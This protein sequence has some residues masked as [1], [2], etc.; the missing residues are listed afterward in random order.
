MKN[1]KL[2]IKGIVEIILATVGILAVTMAWFGTD[3]V[4][5]RSLE[6]QSFSLSRVITVASENVI[7]DEVDSIIQL[8]TEV[9][10]SEFFKTAYKNYLKSK[11]T[12]GL[13]EVLDD[14]YSGRFVTAGILQLDKIRLFDKN[15]NLISKSKQGIDLSD[16]IPEQNK[17]SILGRGRPEKYKP[18]DFYWCSDKQ[19]FLSVVMPIGGLRVKGYLEIVTS[20]DYN[21]KRIEQ[22]LKSPIRITEFDETV[23]QSKEWAA[24]SENHIEVNHSISGVPNDA[25]GIYIQED[26]SHL[27]NSMKEIKYGIV[28]AYTLGIVI[29]LAISLQVLKYKL[30][31]PL[32][33]LIED[34]HK[35]ANSDFTVNLK[36]HGLSELN[37]IVSG[38]QTLVESITNTLLVINKTACKL[39]SIS[40]KLQV[41]THQTASNMTTQYDRTVDL[42]DNMKRMIDSSNTVDHE[43]G[44]SGESARSVSQTAVEGVQIVNHTVGSMGKLNESF[45][46]LSENIETLNS[47]ANNIGVIIATIKSISEQTNLLA[48]NAAIEA[49]RA[50][51][52]GRGFAVV[53]D[54]VRSLA[55]KTQNSAVEIETTVSEFIDVTSKA[56]KATEIA[57]EK[58]N[59]STEYSNN[60]KLSLE[61][62]EQSIQ[63]IVSHNKKIEDAMALQHQAANQVSGNIETIR[64][65]SHDTTEFARNTADNSEILIDDAQQLTITLGKFSLSNEDSSNAEAKDGV[66]DNPILF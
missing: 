37:V 33:E 28:M 19:C 15:L 53:A 34:L 35:I 49:A 16:K 51:E 50:G 41:S 12:Q 3:Q 31:Q 5:K 60:A 63:E 45:S 54:E 40:K 29:I 30:F 48:L 18:Y 4:E 66:D 21:L 10:S 46:H 57:N 55:A 64:T 14:T 61:A 65:L 59:V 13:P 38:V 62:I 11:S 44:L 26:V 9:A 7:G 23:Y 8:G 32:N 17:D 24:D 22:L 36:S 20:P 56:A 2:S 58:V 39:T 25:L 42:T 6:A 1:P 43:I 52:S 47:K 27:T